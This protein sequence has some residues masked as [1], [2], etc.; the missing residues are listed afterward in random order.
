[1]PVSLHWVAPQA[2]LGHGQHESKAITVQASTGQLLTPLFRG[3][4][5]KEESLGLSLTL[6]NFLTHHA[7]S[8]T[9]LSQ[10]PLSTYRAPYL[11]CT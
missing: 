3:C 4:G 8:V 2:P 7:S 1:M 11:A 10:G 9:K 6:H 5:R